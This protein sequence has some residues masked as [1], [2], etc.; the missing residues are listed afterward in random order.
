[1]GFWRKNNNNNL[2]FVIHVL[3]EQPSIQLKRKN[4]H[5]GAIRKKAQN[6]CKKGSLRTRKQKGK[7]QKVLYLI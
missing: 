6:K 2:I 4:K 1:V 7:D 5:K 3:A